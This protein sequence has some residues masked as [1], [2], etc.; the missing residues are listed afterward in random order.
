MKRLENTKVARIQQ[1]EK[2]IELIN[3]ELLNPENFVRNKH[4]DQAENDI[5]ILKEEE[6]DG[7]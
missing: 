5:K 4:A 7:N 3:Q 1:C 2:E 6:Q